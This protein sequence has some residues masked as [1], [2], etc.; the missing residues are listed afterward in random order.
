M[1]PWDPNLLRETVGTPGGKTSIHFGWQDNVSCGIFDTFVTVK[2]HETAGTINYGS[3]ISRLLCHVLVNR[4]PDEG[5]IELCETLSQI[6]DFYSDRREPPPPL[7]P[8]TVRGRVAC[9]TTSPPFAF[10]E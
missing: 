4:I 8:E 2:P 6:Q 3:V 10:E 7:L 5:L 1:K 9:T